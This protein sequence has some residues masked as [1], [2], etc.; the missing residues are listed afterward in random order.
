MGN[1]N[2]SY[3]PPFPDWCMYNESDIESGLWDGER[4]T[5]VK[6]YEYAQL[7]ADF[8][9]Y[10]ESEGIFHD[11]LG[12][13]NETGFIG[14]E[15][16]KRVLE[17]LNKLAALR[18]F[19]IPEKVIAQEGYL[20][21]A[22]W[23]R[24]LIAIN[25]TEHWNT[26]GTHYYSKERDADNKYHR[27]YVQD[28]LRWWAQSLPEGM[29]KWHT[30]V[31]WLTF[32]SIEHFLNEDDSPQYIDQIQGLLAVQADLYDMGF[33]GFA[34]WS[35]MNK[36]NTYEDNVRYQMMQDITR[37]EMNARP[38]LMDDHDGKSADLFT[39]I[40]R[41]LR[42]DDEITVWVS[43]NQDVDYEAYKMTLASGE[44]AACS[45]SE[46]LTVRYQQWYS[47][48]ETEVTKDG[49]KDWTVNVMEYQW[50]DADILATN[51][52]SLPIP[53][54]T[55]TKIT[56]QVVEGDD[57]ATDD[58]KFYA[59]EDMQVVQTDPSSDRMGATMKLNNGV[60]VP[61]W[62]LGA[63]RLPGASGLPASLAP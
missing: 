59:T 27:R 44:L 29:P 36:G 42:R 47:T 9:E 30:E 18:N 31:H 53:K 4:S 33:S 60:C 22:H 45:S 49:G 38:L 26:A 3:Y 56:F 13:E 2:K 61:P 55:A 35:Y 39:L 5:Q 50:A 32:E 21:M 6:P 8:L 23:N 24:E 25:G 20:P 17:E 10:F 41:A 51:A 16:F 14:E 11:I 37:S 7:L 62:R 40:T 1:Y 43:N 12:I 58:F 28:S 48:N 57:P 54:R 52:F 34:W 46:Y 15:T 19:T 63:P